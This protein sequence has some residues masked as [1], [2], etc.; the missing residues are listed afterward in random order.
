MKPEPYAFIANNWSPERYVE[1]KLVTTPATSNYNAL[2]A[3]PQVEEILP[4]LKNKR[5]ALDIGARFGNFTM[6]LHN[7][8]FQHVYMIE[9]L[10]KFMEPISLNIDLSRATVYNFGAFSHTATGTRTGKTLTNTSG[11]GVRLHSIDDLELSDIDFIKIDVDGPDR[12]VLQGGIETIKKYR[13]VIYVEFDEGQVR[14]E[15]QYNN[16]DLNSFEDMWK[17][18]VDEKLDYRQ[19]V[20]SSDS[21]PEKNHYNLILVPN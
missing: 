10:E 11:G 9:M 14:W 1:N 5:N 3:M 2:T 13:P 16:F 12:L 6:A 19:I 7:S 4:F 18:L 21:K 17:I 8:G 15:K 20:A